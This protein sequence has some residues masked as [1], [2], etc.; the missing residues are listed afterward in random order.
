MR[1]PSGGRIWASQGGLSRNKVAVGESAA[2]SPPTD[3][4][5]TDAS[6]PPGAVRS[7]WHT[8]GQAPETPPRLAGP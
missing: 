4:D 7:W 1:P 3:R 2:G 5:Q 8:S 6:D